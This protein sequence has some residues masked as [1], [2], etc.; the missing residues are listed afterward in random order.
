MATGWFSYASKDEELRVHLVELA[1]SILRADPKEGVTPARGWAINVME[2]NSGITFDKEDRDALLSKPIVGKEL[3][4]GKKI[5]LIPVPE[6]MTFEE[7][8]KK[9]N[10]TP[11]KDEIAPTK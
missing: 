10:Q 3:W 5:G 7:A 6:G 2:K 11:D 9:W 4:T 1:I 8:M